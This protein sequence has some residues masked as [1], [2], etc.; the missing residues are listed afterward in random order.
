MLARFE[1]GPERRRPPHAGARMRGAR[2]R[3]R[4]RRGSVVGSPR[5]RPSRSRPRDRRRPPV[6]GFG[7]PFTYTVEV[8]AAAGSADADG[9]G[10]SRTQA[11]FA[12]LAPART[13]RSSRGDESVVRLTQVLA[14]L[15]LACAPTAAARRVE[16]PPARVIATLRAAATPRRPLARCALACAARPSGGRRRRPAG[17]PPGDRPARRHDARLA[18]SARRPPPRRR[19]GAR[20]HSAGLAAGGLLRRR[21]RLGQ[22]AD[23]DP[24]ARALRLLRE[25][26]G[27]PGSDRRRAADLLARALAERGAPPLADEATAVAWSAREPAPGDALALAARGAAARRAT[28]RDRRHP[29]RR[30]TGAG[31]PRAA[32]A[33]GRAGAR[34]C[35]RR[36]RRRSRSRPPSGS[37]ARPAAIFRRGRRGSSSSTSRRASPS[38]TYARIAAT[39]DRLAARD[40][41]TGSSS[42]RTPPTRRCRRERR[43]RSCGRS[44]G[45]SASRARRRP[46]AAPATAAQSLD[47]AVQRRHADLDRSAR[48]PSTSIRASG[49]QPAR[50]CSSAT[51]TTTRRDLE[52]A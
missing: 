32:N 20:R 21:V 15:D 6:V 8:R 2:A 51:S 39:L 14:C 40:G 9:S 7:D 35:A 17:I 52:Q 43:R 22:D 10:S 48:S 37:P 16:L 45:F 3:A 50:C 34:V 23:R 36:A 1:G 4:D 42:S 28:R 29:L 27:R 19:C 24:L 11:P 46:G 25:S 44:S 31:P 12:T 41:R 5:V 30:R 49:S 33:P 13:E 18:R 26:A 38:D 47:G